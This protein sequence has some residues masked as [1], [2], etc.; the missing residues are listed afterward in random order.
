MSIL[1][2]IEAIWQKD[3]TWVLNFI[4]QAKAGFTV[5]ENDLKSFWT[6]LAAHAGEIS[7]DAQAVTA[8]VSTLKAAGMPVPTQ[9]A[10]AVH[11]MNSAV[12]GLNAAV[13]S[14]AS[15]ASAVQV[16]VD[17]YTAAKQAEAAHSAAAIAIVQTPVSSTPSA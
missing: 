8:A 4:Q 10:S 13:T 7:Q 3:E 5:L 17:G 2:N 9:V 12:A 11:A 14:A 6:W 15:G 16:V 1:S